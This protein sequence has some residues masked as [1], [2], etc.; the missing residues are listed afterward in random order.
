MDRQGS[1]SEVVKRFRDILKGE[2]GIPENHHDYYIKWLLDYLYFCKTRALNAAV[3]LHLS[4][5]IES[6]RKSGRRDFQVN[7]AQA[8]VRLYL[9]R[10]CLPVVVK[11]VVA[12][13]VP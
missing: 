10:L 11:A 5:F 1:F 4:H 8:S 2:A 3:P 6:I 7:Q 12:P 13:P 9:T